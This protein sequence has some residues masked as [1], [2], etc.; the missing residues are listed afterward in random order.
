MAQPTRI[1]GIDPGSLTT[2]YG[3]IDSDGRASR[4][5]AHGCIASGGGALAQRLGRIQQELAAVIAETQP[6]EMAVEEVFVH[7]SAAAALK[8]G[9][10]RGAA[11]CAGAGAGLEVAEYSARLVKQSVVG[12]GG[13]AKQQIGHMVAALLAL[14]DRR[15]PEDAA[16]ALA[17]ALC[18]AHMRTRPALPRG[19]RSGRRRALRWTEKD[20]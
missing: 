13:A 2:G 15:L 4:H 3:V 20:L 6:V 17:V 16:D 18:H 19:A 8:L 10:A 5:V 14:D 7:R 1:L 12:A 11:I 9:Q